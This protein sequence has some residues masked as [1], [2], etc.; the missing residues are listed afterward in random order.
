MFTNPLVPSLSDYIVFLQTIARVNNSFLPMVQGIAV[1]GTTNVLVD[2][3]LPD[4][5]VNQWVDP[6]VAYVLMD[7]TLNESSLIQ[8]NDA[9]SV[10]FGPPFTQ[11]IGSGDPYAIFPSIVQTSLMV[12][13]ELVNKAINHG[14]SRLYTLAVY[15]LATDRLLNFA[16]DRSLPTPQSYFKQQRENL[17]IENFTP[18]V[19]SHAGDDNTSAGLLNPEQ[20]K[21]LTL[22][23]LQMLKT[24]YGRQYISIAQAYGNQP[25]GLT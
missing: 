1:S 3:S 15:N 17:K 7:F 6:A 20:M 12:A 22:N 19:V 8:D 4:W 18:G 9:N 23:D 5:Q 2:T 13:L 21:F 16:P 11:T 24:P 10:T 14:S 25:W